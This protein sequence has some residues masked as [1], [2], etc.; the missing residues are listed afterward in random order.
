[1]RLWK[2]FGIL[3]LLGLCA[4]LAW[5][6]YVPLRSDVLGDRPEAIVLNQNNREVQLE[7]R[8]PGLERT[9]GILDGKKWDR[10]QI[11]GGGYELDLGAPE[12]PHFTKLLII[13]ATAAVHAEFEALETYTIRNVQLMPAQGD[14]PELLQINKEAVKYDPAYYQ[15]NELYP[16]QRVMVGE[17]AVMRGLRV[18][19]LRTNPVQYNPVTK[20]LVI[21]TKYRV[22]ARFEGQD[23]RNVPTRQI[24]MTKSWANLVKGASFNFD[25]NAAD[26]QSMGSYLIVC[27]NNAGLIADLQPFIEWKKR[28]GHAVTLQSVATGASTATIKSVIQTAYDTWPTPPEFVLLVGDESGTY[29]LALYSN[30][31]YKIDHPYS[32]LDG[33]D[34]LADVALGRMPSNST[35]NTQTMVNKVLFYEKMPY[36]DNPSW[37]L[38]GGLAAGYSTYNYSLSMYQV[39]RWIKTRWLWAGYTR[40]D[41]IWYY[42]VGGNLPSMMVNSI[43]SGISFINYRG[44]TGAGLSVSQINGLTN[45]R[46]LPFCSDLTCG[47]GGF[48]GTSEMEAYV[49]SGTAQ[50]P[51]GGIASVGL[52]TMNT[53][54]QYNNTIDYGLY[55]GLFEEDITQAGSVVNRSKIEL[56]NAYQQNNSTQVTNFSNW[57]SQ[58]G[59][60]GVDLFTGAIQY[61]N[62][63]VPDQIT[64]GVNSLSLTVNKQV[65]GVL[66]GATVCLYKAN[67]L[68]SVGTTDANGQIT[69]PLTVTAAGNVKVT[70]TKHNYYPIVDSLNVISAAVAVGYQNHTVD[71]DNLSGTTGDNDHVINPGETVDL[72]LTF[73]NFGTSTTATGISLTASETDP[74]T[75]LSNATQSFPDMAPG[76]TGNSSGSLRLA[77]A[78]DCPDGYTLP[79]AFNTTSGQ[80]SWTGG[81]ALP[82]VSYQLTL[83]NAQAIGADTL[84]SPGETANLTLTVKNLGHKNATTLTATLT[85]LDPLV[86]VNDNSASF[87]TI[88]IDGTGNCSGNPFNVTASSTAMRGHWADLRVAYSANGAAQ[89]DTFRLKLGNK[90]I[91]D[92]QGPDEYGYYCFDNGDAG[93]AQTPVYSWVEIDPGFGGSGTLLPLNDPG[94]DLDQSVNLPLPFTF[95]YYGETTNEITVCS[96]GWISTWANNSFNDFRNYE[97][98]SPIGPNGHLCPFWNDLITHSGG[99]VY[100][101]HDAT[102]H[103]FIVEWSRLYV[104]SS[105]TAEVFEV[106]LYDPA[107]YST[108]TGDGEIVFQYHT[109]S[110]IA[111]AYANDNPYS[112][113]GIESPDQRD[114]LEVVYWVTYDDPAAAHL[115]NGR[116]Y[117]FTTA[118]S[119]ASLNLDVTLTPI[120]PPIVVPAQGGS[121]QFTA[122]V[123]N[124]GP[125]PAPFS[126]WARI[127]YPDGTYTAPTLGPVILSPPVGVAVSRLR[128]Q[129]IPSTY[130]TGL[131]TY[132]GYA[133][134]T[135]TYPAVDSSSFTFTKSAVADGGPT[136]WDALCGGELFPGEAPVAL[137]QPSSYSLE[138]AC[139]NPFNPSTAISY[140]LAAFSHVSLRV[141]DTAGR[142][143]STLV[144]N[145]Q[146]AGSHQVTFDG[147]RLSS[148]LYFVKM[149]AGDFRAVQK[150]M[151]IK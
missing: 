106:I 146:E 38:A 39:S 150:M 114:G 13:P 103:R 149:Q 16:S 130:P 34:I 24:P 93:F 75:T 36:V 65:G 63:A 64:Y 7:I 19:T 28:K 134:S 59:D 32:Q 76:A 67:E 3:A 107:Y 14:D 108:P 139:P 45:G 47:S 41:T 101:W 97:I 78:S 71:D 109:I 90:L 33:S 91:T 21:T 9:E 120:N 138:Q 135:F 123:L 141:Y 92:P 20:E 140:Q 117:R 145:W 95:R 61:M 35:T 122:A 124:N 118:L 23:L 12:V 119:S 148:G 83:L 10:V 129:N 27:T 58:A 70:I 46:R 85:S 6:E 96:N 57:C 31:G 127:K 2:T 116:A 131:Y 82:V 37:F 94:E 44:Y 26:E 80:G 100:A 56:Y 112:T 4:S 62:S 11:P 48:N 99:H 22:T 5:G 55:A 144:D 136:V 79:L 29:A 102:N 137:L 73:K 147:S 72:P 60:P 25:D 86:T 8:I 98:P 50:S 43:N 143:V 40:V 133:N 52:A 89:V 1:M 30:S 17:P 84:L 111:N 113:V 81:L 77:I 49:T 110:D 88:N 69:L 132:L 121:F 151:L 142:L 87:G 51:G 68:Q 18:I 115:Q 53:H 125:S 104:A 15:R 74:Y 126:A 42:M 105:S 54:P 66:A 128:T